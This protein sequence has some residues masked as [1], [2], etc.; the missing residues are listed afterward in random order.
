[1]AEETITD[2]ESAQY[3]EG[4]IRT[5]SGLEHIRH[6]PGMYIN[7]LG[8]GLSPDDGVYVLLKEVIDNSIDEFKMKA[9]NQIEVIVEDNLRVSVRDYGR[10]IPQGKL[11]ESV[12]QVNTSGK[13]DSDK[14]K[15][16]FEKSIGMNGVGI[17]ATNALS[18]R[19][20]VSS[21]RDGKVRTA[22]FERGVLKSDVTGPTD[23]KNGTFIFFEPDTKDI[24]LKDSVFGILTMLIYGLV[25]TINIIAHL[26]NG[27]PLKD[28]DW[29]G[30]LGDKISNAFIAIPAMLIVT[31][32]ITLGLW[33]LNRRHFRKN[34]I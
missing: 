26:G 23:Q 4:N 6:R 1:M 27:H 18:S 19:F 20:V 12:S 31:W 15:S 8:S 10:G 7:N 3:D 30:F 22:V 25:Y 33:I 9:G 13:F 32:L 28:Y 29:Y 34:M 17:K 24:S 16:A 2:A 5:L 11:I 21:Y 14:S